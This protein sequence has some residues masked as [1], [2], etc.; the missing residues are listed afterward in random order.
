MYACICKAVT[1]VEVQKAVDDGACT[2][3][4]VSR[5]CR[6]AGGDCGSCRAYIARVIDERRVT[7]PML[8]N[9]AE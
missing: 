6:G 4:D 1:D 3:A 2:L 8:D 7:L 5:A 9:A